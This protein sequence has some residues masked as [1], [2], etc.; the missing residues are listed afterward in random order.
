MSLL[1]P[2]ADAQPAWS[3]KLWISWVKLRTLTVDLGN[4]SYP[5]HVG[6]DLLRTPSWLGDEPA[7]QTV[8]VTDDQVAE[9]YLAPLRDTL[10]KW[11]PLTLTLPSGEQY[12]RL[13]TVE[14]IFD[15]LIEH[16]CGRD[17]LLISLGGGVVGDMAGFAAA[18]YMRGIPFL[19][20]PTTLLAQ[21]DSSVGGKTGVNHPLGK[22]MIGAFHQP[23]AV[24]IDTD[25]LKSLNARQYGAGIAEIIKY[26]LIWDSDFFQWLEAN[27]AALVERREEALVHAVIRSCEIKAQ[28]V[29]R[30]EREGGIRALL[31]LGHTFGHAI[32]TATEYAQWLHGEAVAIGI[33][34]AA[35]LSAQLGLLSAEAVERT[36]ILLARGGLPTELPAGL[37]PSELWARMG[38]DK[39]VIQ[40]RI[41]FVLLDEIGEARISDNVQQREVETMFL[42]GR[43]S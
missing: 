12:K 18:T 25:T 5:I 6:R 28:I 22:N 21:V 26:G 4:R 10:G 8:I 35:R 3:R 34:L 38:Q 14:T 33:V 13:S 24:V 41:R 42:S 37:S 32:E 1:N 43:P 17:A 11:S 15:F 19:Q 29:A 20:V 31:N 7:G 39:K 2:M 36:T 9:H 40:G 27:M 23:R 16:H 30:D